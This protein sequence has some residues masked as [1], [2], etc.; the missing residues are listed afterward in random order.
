MDILILLS[1]AGSTARCWLR[2]R[3]ST[4]GP[5]SLRRG[6][7][8]VGRRRTSHCP[9]AAGQRG[10]Y[11]GA[12]SGVSAR[13]SRSRDARRVS[14]FAL[15]PPR[16]PARLRHARRGRLSARA[17]RLAALE[18]RGL[19]GDPHIS[20]LVV[21]SLAGN[22][23]PDATVEFLRRSARRSRSGWPARSRSVSLSALQKEDGIG[24]GAALGVPF[25]LTLS[26]MNPIVDGTGHCGLC[27]KCR[28][29]RDAF[30]AAGVA[31]PTTYANRSPR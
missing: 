7:S 6:G 1:P 18:S 14:R 23:F 8:G 22:P 4:H 19:C 3:P 2:T 11:D 20:R 16:H 30:A 12:Q 13:P 25:E 17:K 10:V 26:C 21:A 9:I 15:G 28:E 27:S 24:L 31:D 5:S 29:R